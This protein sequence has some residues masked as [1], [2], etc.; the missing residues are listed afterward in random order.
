MTEEQSLDWLA[1]IWGFPFYRYLIFITRE[2]KFVSLNY[3]R[4]LVFMPSGGVMT[5]MPDSKI[6]LTYWKVL[7]AN[8]FL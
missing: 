8:N 5:K 7:P 1:E 2:K 3:K 4:Q 6:F